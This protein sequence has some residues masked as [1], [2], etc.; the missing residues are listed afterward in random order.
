MGSTGRRFSIQKGDDSCHMPSTT[1]DGSQAAANA[2]A[3]SAK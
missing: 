3:Q 1:S 2:A